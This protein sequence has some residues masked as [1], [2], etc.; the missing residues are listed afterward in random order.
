MNFDSI[1]TFKLFSLITFVVLPYVLLSKS[2]MSMLFNKILYL[3]TA[4]SAINTLITD[5]VYLLFYVPYTK[6]II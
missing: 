3:L 4:E 5:N 6:Y 2:L 1:F